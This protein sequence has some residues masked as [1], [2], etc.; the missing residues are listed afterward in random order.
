MLREKCP[1]TRT[2]LVEPSG[3]AVISG[4]EPGHHRIQGIGE[5]F[6]PD[7]MDVSLADEIVQV[8]DE[9]AIATTRRLWREEGVMAGLSSGANVY[10]ALQV[11]AK[12]SAGDIVVTIIPDS[13][14]R[15]LS[16]K[17]LQDR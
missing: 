6:I 15:Y 8:G 4:C 1:G 14:A 3:S 12:M 5:G 9:E 11:A 2:V 17:E 13:G 7:T 16:I 10:A